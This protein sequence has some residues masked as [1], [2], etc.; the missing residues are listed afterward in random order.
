M[1]EILEPT[2]AEKYYLEPMLMYRFMLI[3]LQ[4]QCLHLTYQPS[5]RIRNIPYFFGEI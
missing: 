2:D 3:A 5:D 1:E 4:V